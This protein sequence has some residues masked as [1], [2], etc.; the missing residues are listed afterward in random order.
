MQEDAEFDG[1]EFEFGKT[2]DMGSGEL[3]LSF[4]RDVVNA[5]F[6]MGIMFQE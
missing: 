3:S 1:Y 4:G 6:R 2:F 5:K